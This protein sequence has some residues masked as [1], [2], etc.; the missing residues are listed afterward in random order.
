MRVF[1]IISKQVMMPLFCMMSYLT[2]T[3]TILVVYLR[4]HVSFIHSLIDLDIHSFKTFIKHLSINLLLNNVSLFVSLQN[5]SIIDIILVTIFLIYLTASLVFCD[6]V[7]YQNNGLNYSWKIY[8]NFLWISESVKRQL[9]E[10]GSTF[11]FCCF[12]PNA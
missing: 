3:C 1:T 10:S 8:L 11:T 4:P 2:S 12:C 7:N 9:N 6:S 5:G